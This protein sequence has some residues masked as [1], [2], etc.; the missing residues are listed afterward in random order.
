MSALDLTRGDLI[1]A[2]PALA[3][4]PAVDARGAAAGGGARRGGSDAAGDR[5]R[6]RSR[7]GPGDYV[8]DGHRAGTVR[9]RVRLAST[10][11]PTR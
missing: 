3:A 6:G 8:V 11:R 9:A 5:R 2:L 4:R 7:R 10:R 1:R